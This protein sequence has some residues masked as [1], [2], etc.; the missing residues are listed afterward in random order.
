M[1]CAKCLDLCVII[2]L[3]N[4][5]N[6]VGVDI[7]YD[8]PKVHF[9]LENHHTTNLNKKLALLFSEIGIFWQIFN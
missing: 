3:L 4:Y 6:V 9:V 8:E 1:F 7:D 2:S 5:N